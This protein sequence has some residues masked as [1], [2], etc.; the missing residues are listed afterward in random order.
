MAPA[1]RPY[2]ADGSAAAAR[3]GGPGA[4]DRGRFAL[5][6]AGE[7][8]GSLAVGAGGERRP[9]ARREVLQVELHIHVFALLPGRER[10][11]VG[12]QLTLQLLFRQDRGVF[13]ELRHLGG[14]SPSPQ[15]SHPPLTPARSLLARGRGGRAPASEPHG[16]RPGLA[17]R[18]P[19]ETRAHKAKPKADTK[20]PAGQ[21]RP[22]AA[23]PGVRTNPSPHTTARGEESLR[24]RPK[25]ARRHWPT[26]GGSAA[27]IGRTPRAGSISRGALREVVETQFKSRSGGSP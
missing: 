6:V 17:P 4:E 25:K 12:D 27:V 10:H 22:S 13:Q 26:T 15:P 1:G 23:K 20:A 11:I 3:D 14:E 21:V 19:A 5:L 16:S 9:V 18:S 2:P 7:V 8:R 24:P